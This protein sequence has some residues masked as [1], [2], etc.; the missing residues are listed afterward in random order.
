MRKHMFS[1]V[2]DL[3]AYVLMC[4]M[5]IQGAWPCGSVVLVWQIAQIPFNNSIWCIESCCLH[6]ISNSLPMSFWHTIEIE[7][8]SKLPSHSC[9]LYTCTQ[10]CHVACGFAWWRQW[11]AQLPESCTDKIY[12]SEMR[13]LLSGTCSD[14]S[15]NMWSHV[16]EV[17]TLL[18]P[19]LLS[20][21]L[22]TFFSNQALISV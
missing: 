5:C 9:V 6:G 20:I 7:L 4:L 22:F 13:K 17:F 19:R 18:M 2:S 21:P 11:I 16:S 3:R 15:H 14:L 10:V 1:A 12:L 8:S